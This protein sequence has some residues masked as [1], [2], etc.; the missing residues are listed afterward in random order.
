MMKIA[1]LGT[2]IVGRT[3]AGRLRGLGHEVVMGTRDVAG[4]LAKQKEDSPLT[5]WM[6][7]HP[8]VPL[9]PFAAAASGSDMLVN[10]VGGLVS[11]AALEASGEAS[12]NGKLLIDIANP[13]DFSQGMPPFLNPVNTDSLGE[14]IQKR[15]PELKVVKTLNTMNAH[16]MVDPSKVPG[17][18]NVFVSGNDEGAKNEAKEI[19]NSFGW[20]ADQILDLGDITTARGT[21]MLLPVW[22]RLWQSLGTAEFNFHIQ[23]K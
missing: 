1:V 17:D 19:L 22:L 11:I 18:H 2:G 14:Q 23:R 7:D 8:D 21:E 20:K 3:L 9:K 12:L 16:I 4:T 15:F 5:N 10:C 6:K 13:L